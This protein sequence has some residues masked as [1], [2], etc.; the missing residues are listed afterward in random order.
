[1]LQGKALP[2]GSVQKLYKIL[3]TQRF[4][5]KI[6][7][8]RTKSLKYYLA[9]S[10]SLITFLVYLASL[11]N[12]FVNWD[13]D[14][15]VY[16]N[17]H[18][19]SLNASF[20]KWAFLNISQVD[21]WR[22]LSY[23][24]HALDYAVWG[25][26]PLGHHLTNNIL[27]AVNTF[28]V[29]ILVVRLLSIVNE[30]A[31]LSSI[32]PPQKEGT[33]IPLAPSGEGEGVGT[34]FI[35]AAT[36]GLLFGLHPLHV[37][38]VVWVTERKDLLCALF[39]LLSILAYIEYGGSITLLLPSYFKRGW[40]SWEPFLLSLALFTLALMSKPMAVTL[41][42]VLLILDW[43]PLERI[44]TL[45]TFWNALVEKLPFIALSFI[46]SILAVMAQKAVGAMTMTES[47][48]LSLRVS[49][50]AKSFIGYVGKMILPTNLIPFYP[51]PKD[52]SPMSLSYLLPV[53]SMVGI[54]LICIIIARKRRSW[55]SLWAY[56]V[57]TLIPVIGLVQVGKQ[58]M[59]DRYT[60]LPSLG[61][62]LMAGLAMAWG[63]S[64]VNTP[65]RMSAVVK[66]FGISAF[67]L[68]SATMMY[69]T[70]EQT[71]IWKDSMTLWSYVI[72]KEPES[73]PFAYN[74]RGLVF[75][76]V[77]KL[78]K[79]IE[80]YDKAIALSPSYAL[81]YNNRGLVFD[82]MGRLDKAKEDYDKAIAL[83]PSYSYAYI[84]RGL[85]FDKMG[86]LD[87]AIEDYDKAI[88]LS[89]SD[90]NVYNNRGLVF[91][92][93]GR[94][95]KAKEDYDRAIAFNPSY[96]N[97]YYNRGSVFAQMGM[98]D[99]A[100]EDYDKAIALAP[101]DPNVYN[102]RGVV[103][104]KMGRVDKAMEDYDKAIALAPSYALAYNNRGLVFD[105][106]GRFDKAI[107]DYDRAI[108][109]NPSDPN[110]YYNRGL[111]FAKMGRLDKSREDYD[112]AI[113]LNPSDPDVYYNR[114]LVFDKMGRL[115]KAIADF[116]K[117]CDLGHREGCRAAQTLRRR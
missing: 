71:G 22:P 49:V 95:D 34:I 30:K 48:P 21:Y 68:L 58:A 31:A 63:W 35:A 59:A 43:Y 102:N 51:Y 90:P 17:P 61:P 33:A 42:I 100:M 6:I 76:K 60:Y 50:A 1:M 46:A 47:V 92:K 41:P 112:K 67:M 107:E 44:R 37:E 13:D 79:A 80:D 11:R 27:H 39:F 96:P 53:V 56:Y 105:K 7:S 29:V 83:A 62:F 115:D 45:R 64:R 91:H 81:A 111:V 25:L 19:R 113:A 77:G 2:A 8:H 52:I 93:M 109:L 55:L 103:L 16:N 26:N 73:A 98:F 20:F 40:R 66:L 75:D 36:T 5:E 15:N 104:E 78:D 14:L 88:A 97:A 9:V 114:G 87:K 86:R 106:M 18:I 69:L 116:K 28:L 23:L 117:S 99:K 82:K 72:E 54:T 70:F 10:L 24:S 32:H 38:S 74:N 12:D 3:M 65:G 57:V 110:A 4:L 85:V 94:L 89:P 108:D 84:N 101:S